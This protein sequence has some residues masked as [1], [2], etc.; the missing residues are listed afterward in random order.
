VPV[1]VVDVR[2]MRMGVRQRFVAVG[3]RVRAFDRRV[4]GML[5]MLIVNVTMRVFD[6]GVKVLV[7]MAF[8]NVEPGA[9][10]HQASGKNQQRRWRLV[11][12]NQ[13]QKGP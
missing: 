2:V 1:A 9:E 7:R 12:Q 3:V 5:M 11:Q 6:G 10:G 13:R 4:V 8:G